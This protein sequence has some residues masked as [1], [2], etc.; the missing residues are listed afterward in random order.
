MRGVPSYAARLKEIKIR[1]AVG[2]RDP[3]RMETLKFASA[4]SEHSI[5]FLVVGGHLEGVRRQLEHSVFHFFDA[6][7]N[8]ELSI[9]E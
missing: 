6:F 5:A 7:F 2:S 8:V 1:L 4:L 9:Q 3:A